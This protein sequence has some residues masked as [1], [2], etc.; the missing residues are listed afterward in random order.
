[1]TEFG[2][3]LS[4]EEHAPN[5]LVRYAQRAE[6][7][8]FSFAA[9][10]DHYH[11][12]VDQQ[13]HAPF[14]WSVIGGIAHATSTLK[15]GT[16]VTCPTFRIHPAI[17]A[18]AAATA[19]TM[20]PGRF[21]LG[22]GSGE[23]LNEHILGDHWPPAPVRQDMLAEAISLI[24]QLWEGGYQSFDGAYYTVEN[25][26]IYTL[27]EELPPIIM[28][29]ADAGVRPPLIRGLLGRVLVGRPA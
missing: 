22:V 2:Y 17:I 3:A 21:F 18:Q 1:M 9:V 29:A 15:L 16:G 19:A 23:N 10:S 4:S 5:D 6:A 27:P 26:R 12:W 14:V 8:G 11:P 28:A 7:V 24:R 25:A 13:G 20:M